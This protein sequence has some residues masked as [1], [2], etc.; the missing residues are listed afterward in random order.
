MQA[1]MVNS[2]FDRSQFKTDDPLE[3]ESFPKMVNIDLCSLTAP[4]AE[5]LPFIAVMI[6]LCLHKEPDQN[7][8]S[9]N[10]DTQKEHE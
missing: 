2:Q 9:P 7:P 3:P 1:S 6:R 4:K 5:S 8:L 10:S